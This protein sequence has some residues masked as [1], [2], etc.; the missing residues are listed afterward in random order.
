MKRIFSFLFAAVMVMAITLES[1]SAE[2][3]S[4]AEENV[5]TSGQIA[6]STGET[7]VESDILFIG[8][9]MT[10][11][12]T[13]CKVVEGIAARK[14][15]TIHCSAATNGGKN[16]VYQSG[17]DNV[18]AA[19]RK[20]GYEVVILQ[21]IVGGFD[22]QKLQTGADAL[23]PKIKQ[24]NP[25]ARII[26]YE[27]WPTKNTIT[28]EGSLLPY[29]TESYIKTAKSVGAG[30]AP[31]GEAFYE[32]YTAYKLDFYCSDRKHPKP[33]G[34]FVS[35][36]AIYYTLYPNDAYEAFS[37]QDQTYLDRLINQNVAY[38]TEGVESTYSLNTLNLIFS[39]GY[40]Y[41]H[42]V[43]PAVNGTGSYTSAAG[44]YQEPAT[45]ESTADDYGKKLATFRKSGRV[46]V[47]KAV[48][49]KS[50][51]QAEITLKRKIKAADGYQIRFYRTK[52]NAK[53]NKKGLAKITYRKNRKIFT[54]A[55]RKI[56]NKKQL[57][58]R[59]RAYIRIAGKRKFS[60]WSAVRKVRVK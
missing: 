56:K 1:I 32:L 48:K 38:T 41:A 23:I 34:T 35:A 15:K 49:K 4:G 21:D 42:A 45:E 19:I 6:E 14:G 5:Q 28:G 58:V 25:D 47:K 44:A 17:A 30:L 46:S 27:P 51:K 26:F 52:K 10:Y 53:N 57:Y 9:S 59:V 11:Y 54:V 60:K 29:F 31:A 33:L 7:T 37:N 22:A 43:I 50:A 18:S 16:L 36:S 24:Y 12:N 39:L 13:L 20:G 2:N 3:M 8:N 55:S 40:K